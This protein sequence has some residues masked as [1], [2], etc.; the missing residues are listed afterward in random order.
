MDA[1]LLTGQTTLVS[2][3]ANQED[4]FDCVEGITGEPRKGIYRSR[5]TLT[6]SFENETLIG[7]AGEGGLDMI[8]DLRTICQYQ[9]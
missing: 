7:I 3:I 8:D 1:R 2:R 9:D 4:S 5:G 6:V